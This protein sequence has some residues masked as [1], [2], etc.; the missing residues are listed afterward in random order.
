M[1]VIPDFGF[2]PDINRG[3]FTGWQFVMEIIND[4]SKYE[5]VQN[6]KDAKD[7]QAKEKEIF[8]KK[9]AKQRERRQK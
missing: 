6:Y 8:E 2:D 5:R 7:F 9:K 4:L 1:S 3:Q